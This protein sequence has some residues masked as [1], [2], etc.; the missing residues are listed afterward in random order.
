MLNDVL[1]AELTAVKQHLIHPRM[2]V[3]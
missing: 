3:K 2:V 1:T